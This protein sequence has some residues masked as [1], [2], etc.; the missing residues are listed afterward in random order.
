MDNKGVI[1]VLKANVADCREKGISS[2]SIEDIERLATELENDP[3]LVADDALREHRIDLDRQMRVE[4]YK[5]R[6]SGSSKRFEFRVR[7]AELMTNMT[8]KTGENAVKSLLVVNGGAALALLAFLGSVA[9]MSDDLAIKSDIANS[10]AIFTFGA[11]LAA[12]TSGLTFFS[13]AGFGGEFGNH[14]ASVG[15]WF[16]RAAI[17]SAVLSTA[18]F[19]VG[20]WVSAKAFGADII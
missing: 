5:A 3:D 16:R 20:A 12:L 18:G 14:S 13:Q 10:L 8:V 6:L 1:E 15:Y 11:F 2:V 9:R 19:V 17:A 7:R 4:S